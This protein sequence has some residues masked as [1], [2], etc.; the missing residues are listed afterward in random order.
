MA[1]CGDCPSPEEIAVACASIRDA[2]PS[3]RLK[4]A[5][6]QEYRG[7]TRADQYIYRVAGV[8]D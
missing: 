5:R 7:S 6:R 4:Q 3:W 8:A 2:W 1:M